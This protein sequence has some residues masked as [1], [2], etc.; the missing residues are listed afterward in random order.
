MRIP[1]AA[2]AT[3]M[4]LVVL[5]V[6]AA[7][8]FAAPATMPAPTGPHEVNGVR[9]G[10]VAGGSPRLAVATPGAA[11]VPGSPP[12]AALPSGADGPD[13]EADARGAALVW[14]S[15][16]SSVEGD[17]LYLAPGATTPVTLAADAA[18]EQDPALSPDGTRVAFASDRAGGLDVWVVKVDG[19][20]LTRVTD[21]PA[22]DTQPSWSPDGTRLVFT[23]TRDDSEGDLYTVAV[24]GGAVTR[25]TAT[26]G[27]D[28]DPAWSPSGNRIAFTHGT[29]VV[30]MPAGGGAPTRVTPA[31]AVASQPAWAPAG[32]RIAYTSRAADRRGDVQVVPA[33]GGTPVAVAANADTPESEPTWRVRPGTAPEVVYSTI[34]GVAGRDD[35][36]SVDVFG[37]RDNRVDH[38]NRPGGIER[39]PSFSGDGTRLAYTEVN[40]K[41]F[42]RIM[43]ADADGRNARP[44]TAFQAG[45]SD[46]RP[47]WSPDGTLIAFDRSGGDEAHPARITI[48]DAVLG[49]VRATVGVP[50]LPSGE[51]STFLDRDP[52]WSADGTRIAFTRDL[53]GTGEFPPPSEIWYAAIQRGSGGSVVVGAQTDFSEVVNRAACFG[54]TV[55]F[56]IEDHD[57]AFAPFG[58]RIAFMV[59]GHLCT[60]GIDGSAPRVIELPAN[61]SNVSQPAWTPAS[62]VS[63]T[64]GCI[65][66]SCR[67]TIWLSDGLGN[68]F[69]GSVSKLLDLPGG[70]SSP[71]FQRLM[72][73]LTVSVSAA[74][75]PARVGED[76][77]LTYTVRN[78]S[79]LPARR[80]WLAV[81]PPGGL[82]FTGFAPADRCT[83]TTRACLIRDLAP[84][85]AFTATAIVHSGHAVDGV[86][87][88]RAAASFYDGPASTLGET[89]FLVLAPSTAYRLTYVSADTPHLADSVPGSGT[90][91]PVLSGA[92]SGPDT[93][94]SA[95]GSALVWVSRRAAPGTAE[96]D[97][98]VFYLAP[99]TTT[100][101]RLTD[102]GAVDRH[103]VLSPDGQR[104]AFASSRSGSFDLW[105]VNVNGTGLTRLTDHPADDNWPSWSPDGTRLVF[106]SNRD[107]P[108]GA[109]YTV[110]VA[111][112][113]VTRL[114]NGAGPNVEPAWSPDGTRV[115]FRHGDDVLAMPAAGGALTQ[116][117]PAGAVASQ[118]A[119]APDGTRLAY[120]SRRDD[121]AG[122]LYTVPAGGGVPTPVAVTANTGQSDPTWWQPPG[123]GPVQVA[124]TLISDGGGATSTTD[125]WSADPVGRQRRDLTNR[126]GRDET[127]PAYSL[128]GSR[129]AYNE[130][131]AQGDSRIVVADADGGNPRALT[132]FAAPTV[133]DTDPTWSP[134]GTMIAFS[135]VTQGAE[136]PSTAVIVFVRV[137][138]GTVLGQVPMVAGSTGLDF[139]PAWSPTDVTKLA[140]SRF[141]RPTAPGSFGG[142]N[143]WLLTLG[144]TAAQVS[145]TA[146]AKLTG[147]SNLPCQNNRE[148][149][150]PAWSP[151]GRSI[152][153]VSLD[154]GIG[155]LCVIDAN[156]QNPRSPVIGPVAGPQPGDVSDPA[157]SP[158][159]A[160]IAFAD[161]EGPCF[162]EGLALRAACLN[163]TYSI[164]VVPAGGG[165]AHEVIHTPG[166]AREP[167]YQ[168][169]VQGTVT[170]DVAVSPAKGYVGGDPIVVR[171]TVHN[172]MSQPV[173]ATWLTTSLPAGLPVR[174]ASVQ[175]TANGALCGLGTVPAG[176]TVTVTVTLG[177]DVALT[178]L[179]SGHL[180]YTPVDGAPATI[181]RSAPVVVV[182]PVL[183]VDPPIGPPGFVTVATGTNFP[184]DAVLKLVWQQGI[185]APS[186][187][188]VDASGGFRA[189]VLVFHKDRLGPRLLVAVQV[190]GPAFGNVTTA[191]PFLVVPRTQDPPN[192]VGRG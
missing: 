113:A 29:D 160:L 42:G 158:D 181:D 16:R 177:P 27:R 50:P 10:Y 165:V 24:S 25:L 80:A 56:G 190:G 111:D 19:T 30:T 174:T 119:W 33:S 66:T 43:V 65:A 132:P 143:I 31:G 155:D 20:G 170:L 67:P 122:D 23:S 91:A 35:I 3:V 123:G 110:S 93:E 159:G 188:T 34:A 53:P 141:A 121:P 112:H 55:P 108:A 48:V 125:V 75:Q 124:Y 64:V 128:D 76:V 134:D 85:T 192:F 191:R 180:T 115:A 39:S 149:Q 98:D 185:S 13:G 18:T 51:S 86:A 117:T 133:S 120:T 162:P 12:P 59:G 183:T 21:H 46:D 168:R 131:D 17:L 70:V 164:W 52:T 82:A 102:D 57:P 182:Q 79:A 129:L 32:D 161:Q 142:R 118:P 88:A 37:T 60:A 101:V 89:P 84:Q 73:G 44:L 144:V 147:T 2:K 138:D 172:G 94:V 151:D 173:T 40:D 22:D 81:D 186:E 47:D 148:A 71:T 99:G 96:P 175:C 92:A 83:V 127:G 163:S 154:E 97:G 139:E 36:W 95:R 105:L 14:I 28:A 5:L 106:T 63:Y 104:V 146:Q 169:A 15:T 114:T 171:Y 103:P 137:S 184:P 68:H 54:G 62:D 11:P 38:T 179:A 166:G 4:V 100:P 150:A 130:L 167:A 1:A 107:D 69:P 152:A 61:A 156:G 72:G 58:T 109:L 135:R 78:T 9:M 90:V 126:P 87:R 153:F 189:Q 45:R 26:P 187:I 74:P 6:G 178:G 136:G 116:V 8:P 140:V 7:A 176:G 49:A 157:W 41:G 77:R 145:V